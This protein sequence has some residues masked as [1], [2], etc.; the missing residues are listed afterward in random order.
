MSWSHSCQLF[1]QANHSG[2]IINFGYSSQDDICS[3]ESFGKST[4]EELK[5]ATSQPLNM[6]LPSLNSLATV[7]SLPVVMSVEFK[8]I[9]MPPKISMS[10]KRVNDDGSY[11]SEDVGFDGL[12]DDCIST[13]T[14]QV[15]SRHRLGSL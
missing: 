13:H 10:L 9:L 2:S 8:P 15:G 11:S 6:D 7:G 14:F 4:F 5:S 1:N 3:C 12:L